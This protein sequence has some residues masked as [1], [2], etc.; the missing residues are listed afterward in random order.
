MSKYCDKCTL[1]QCMGSQCPHEK[2]FHRRMRWAQTI[3]STTA[4]IFAVIALLIISKL[5]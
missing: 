5:G 2:I 3:L 1:A 4:L